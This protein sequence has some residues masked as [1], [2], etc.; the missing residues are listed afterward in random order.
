MNIGSNITSLGYKGCQSWLSQ[1]NK[2]CKIK[3]IDLFVENCFDFPHEFNFFTE[4]F[5]AFLK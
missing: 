4:Y 2:N 5:I 1:A 3:A